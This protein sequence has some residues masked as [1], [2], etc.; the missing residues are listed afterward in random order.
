MS[1]K[2]KRLLKKLN[3]NACTTEE[4]DWLFNWAKSLPKEE[5]APIL[6]ALWEQPNLNAGV[7][8]PNSEK[9]FQNIKRKLKPSKKSPLKV[10]STR[11]AWVKSYVAV[12]TVLLLFGFFNWWLGKVPTIGIKTIATNYAE[13]KE[14]K[15]PDGST[16]LLNANSSVSFPTYWAN[17]Q[18]REV[19]LK[20]EAF[21]KVEKKERTKQ[22]F[23]VQTDDVTVEVLGTAFNVNT[24]QEKTAVFLEEGKVKLNYGENTK[25]MQPGELVSY[26]ANTHKVVSNAQKVNTKI[27]TSW[28]S[29]VVRFEK[30]AL[31]EVLQEM[32]AIYGIDIQVKN[33]AHLERAI[34][35]GFPIEDLNIA[36]KLL[37]DALKLE[38]KKEEQ[39]YLIQ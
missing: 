12:A 21:F 3:Q 24:R 30:L 10:V 8:A 5:A 6:K 16:V 13:F 4:I 17:N 20:G 23:Q 39:H 37:E 18:T 2:G 14:L 19:W 36:L 27:L 38:I 15:L 26:S 7:M 29:G 28:T 1:A 9:M 32:E 33:T 31:K 22:K 11:R 35:T 25:L 34:T